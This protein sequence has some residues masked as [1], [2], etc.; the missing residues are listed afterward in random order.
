M[1]LDRVDQ[2][3]VSTLHHHLVATE[4]RRG[5][6]FETFRDAIELQ[7]VILPDAQ[8]ARGRFRIRAVD[9]SEDRIFGSDDANEAI[10]VLQWPRQALL[11]LL[12]LVE[13]D[14]ACSETQ[15]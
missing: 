9:V 5:E 4:I 13:R 10:L 2:L 3:P 7:P 14:D 12:E 15:A 11:V 1:K 8:D 6:Q